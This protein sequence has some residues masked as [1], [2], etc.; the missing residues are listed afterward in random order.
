MDNKEK[1]CRELLRKIRSG[2]IKTQGKLEKEKVTVSRKY[3]LDFV[4]RNSDIADLTK[5]VRIK[6]MLKTKPVR[7]LSGVA[8]IAVMWLPASKDELC[9]GSCIYCPSGEASPKSYT[10][11]EPATLRAIRT[12]YDPHLQVTNRL[13]QLKAIGHPTDKCE[14]IVM[15]G[16]F[17]AWSKK[18]QK[19]FIKRCFDAFNQKE[20]KSLEQ[21]QK[22]NE[23]ARHRCIG[24][25]IE[26]RADYC[27]DKDI[28]WALKLG[29]TRM[30]I[31][32]QSTDDKILKMVKRG[33]TTKE[34]ISA[35]KRLKQAGLKVCVHWM[36]GLTGLKKLDMKK[37][38]H[39]FKQIFS[40]PDYRPDELK[41]YP[42]LVIEGTVLC[43][44]W[45]KH[46]YNPLTISQMTKLMLKMKKDVP[47]YVR[48]K[49][50]MRDIS[51]KGV[52]AGP[53][54]TNL[55]QLVSQNMVKHGIRCNCIRCREVGLSGKRPE[56]I[57]L[58]KMEYQ[59]SR[60]KEIFLSFEDKKN[61][62]LLAFLRLRI[63]NNKIA[64]VR[65][66]HVYGQMTELGKKGA[67]QH[68]GFGKQLLK[69]AEKISKASCKKIQITSGIG[70]REYYRKLGYSLEGSYMSKRL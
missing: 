65:E 10:G 13:K 63:D 57:E 44:M 5:D 23:K 46:R 70:A 43:E 59:A 35:I 47:E 39:L 48:I 33:H 42:T 16:T 38:A 41:I 9:P 66:L 14:L 64:R 58:R 31:G 51:E 29:C 49:R 21:A 53:K 25:T 19:N 56:N 68:K 6:K 30:E 45:K 11:S 27:S 12:N 4:I 28:K 69:Q 60:G 24:L 3:S 20:S 32:V 50:I 62:I 34:N 7:T 55:R 37:E 8:N 54:T 26:T 36:P 61:K 1:A 22:L 18:N 67:Y 17:L 15:G 2:K 40:N 52:V